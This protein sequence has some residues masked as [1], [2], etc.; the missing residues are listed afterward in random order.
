MS[1]SKNLEKL[2]HSLAHVLAH[3]VNDLFENV[4]FG[5]GPAIENGFYYD[6]DFGESEISKEDL[7][8]IEKKMKELIKEDIKFEKKEIER[9]KA[10][11][12]FKNQ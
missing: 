3:A 12:L 9:E 5:I 1:N 11:E 8:K 6:F 4:K 7:P 10:K 2:R